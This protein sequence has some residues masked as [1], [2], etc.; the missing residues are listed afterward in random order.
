MARFN[1]KP[2]QKIVPITVNREGNIAYD[3]S[4]EEK[5]VSLILTSLLKDQFY[6]SG[7]QSLQE[8]V[9]LVQNVSPEFA[10][11]CAI[12]ARHKFGIR[13]V[14]HVIGALLPN[15]VKGQP[16][17]YNKKKDPI[18]PR[19]FVRNIVRRPDDMLEIMSF[20]FLLKDKDEAIPNSLKRGLADAFDKF[21]NYQIAK[22]RGETRDFKLI[23]LVRLVHPVPRPNNAAALKAL[24][25]GNLVSNDTWESEL[26]R[27]GQQAKSE[28]EKLAL[29]SEVWKD[30]IFNRKIGYMALLRNIRN[31]IQQADE[32]T[33]VLA[34]TL[35]Q[36]K[37]LIKNSL[38]FPYRFAVAAKQINNA[39]WNTAFNNA[40]KIALDNVPFLPGKNLIVCDVSKSM[41][42]GG[43]NSLSPQEISGIFA[44]QIACKSPCDIIAFGTTAAYINPQFRDILSAGKS[45]T[46]L[47]N[48]HNVGWSTNID[49]VFEL[50]I[51]DHKA[52]DRIMVFTDMQVNTYSSYVNSGQPTQ[53]VLNRYKKITKSDPFIYWFDLNGYGNTQL[54]QR[55][56]TQI[57]GYSDKIFDFMK[58]AEEDPNIVINTIKSF[59]IN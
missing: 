52:Y 42:S 31:I 30:L 56:L 26:T 38:I 6:R 49:S 40:I 4:N 59:D 46:V 27:T 50:L 36:D 11:K 8:L 58:F 5:L 55:K 14:S 35:L 12:F 45:I 28:E 10:A 53:N 24:V 54:K 34:W 37:E 23:D 51:K 29:K 7:E 9:N 18:F 39:W 20:H 2:L 32:D 1:F 57:S 25:E 44:A 48:K 19:D 16:I 15:L 33:K 21:D 41:Q 43:Q 47:G 22:Y 3:L 13:S 17:C